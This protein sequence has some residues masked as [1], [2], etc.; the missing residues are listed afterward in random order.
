MYKLEFLKP[1]RKDLKKLLPQTREFIINDSLPKLQHKPYQG[2]QL[3]NELKK[4][5]KYSIKHKGV[6]YRIIYQIYNQEEIIL[7]IAIGA[8]EKFYERILRRLK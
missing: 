7:I 2:I 5:Y 8:R 4:Y 3:R 6:T 1:V